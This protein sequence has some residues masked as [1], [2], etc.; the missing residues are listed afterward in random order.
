MSFPL[1]VMALI[2]TLLISILVVCICCALLCTRG[3][4]WEEEMG[5]DTGSS[6]EPKSV[7]VSPSLHSIMDTN[8]RE[9]SLSSLSSLPPID[10]HLVRVMEND[11]VGGVALDRM[12]R[13]TA[14]ALAVERILKDGQSSPL[15]NHLSLPQPSAVRVVASKRDFL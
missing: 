12:D 6:I 3:D 2:I 8:T 14:E 4:P 7:V 13:A 5:V 1:T 11:P 9:T 15:F 10:E